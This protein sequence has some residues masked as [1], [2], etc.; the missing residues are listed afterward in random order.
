MELGSLMPDCIYFIG[1]VTTLG[2]AP[3][4]G[5]RFIHWIHSK[6]GLGPV[7]Y[8]IKASNSQVCACNKLRFPVF[9]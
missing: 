8:T 9:A 5:M 6:M 2:S 1:V 3:R 7:L 4:H